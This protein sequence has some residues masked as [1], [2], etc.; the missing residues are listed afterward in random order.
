MRI[1]ALDVGD[2][3]IGVALSDP[4]GILA[5]AISV[6]KRSNKQRDVEKIAALAVEH[7]VETIVVGLP[8]RLDGTIG[9]QA[10]KVQSFARDLERKASQPIV[11]W[12]E[13]LTTAAAERMMIEAGFKRQK[14]KERIDAAAAALILQGY[15]DYIAS[16]KPSPEQRIEGSSC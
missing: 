13:R 11:F 1:M 9:E 16:S 6:I 4:E 3:R 14:R 10:A 7:E 12:D 5:S 15:L 2:R 8:A